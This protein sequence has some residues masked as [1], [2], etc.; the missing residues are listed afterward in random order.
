MER[1]RRLLKLFDSL[2]HVTRDGT[3]L[4][5]RRYDASLARLLAEMEL[6]GSCRACLV[7][8]ADHADNETVVQ[9]A[10]LFPD[11]FVP[12]GSINPCAMADSQ[13]V[14]AAVA[15]LARR[16]F[17]G[18]K[19]HARLNQYDPLD[20]RSLTA[21]DAAGR[22]GLVLFLC[23]LFRQRGRAL[24]GAADIVDQIANR[25]GNTKIVLL[26]GGGASALD[27]FELVRMH[28]HLVLDLSFTM[29]RYAG[30]SLDLDIS[31]LCR[32]LDQRLTVGSDF[33]E[34]TPTEA[35]ERV[36]KL[37]AELPSEKRENILW[38]NLDNLFADWR[39]I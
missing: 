21:M 28:A 14:E 15:D 26:H 9:C 31:F 34:Y 8:I 5:A 7:A 10:R 18:L 2:V 30:S 37:T 27:L 20:P 25:C 24:P 32:E 23:T 1:A 3:W 17:A 36:L 29:L 6:L 38:R 13:E 4:G 19:L 39:G 11:R 35:L 12:I 16:G 33:P 22:H